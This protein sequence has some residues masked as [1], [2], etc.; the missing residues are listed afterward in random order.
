MNSPQSGGYKTLLSVG[1][2]AKRTGV[3]V[4]ALHFYE[5]KGLIKASRT[6]GNQRQYNR[7]VLRRVSVIKVAQR[8]GISLASIHDAFAA[9]PN[10]RIA[11][12]EDWSKLS[13][14][15]KSDLDD[16]IQRLTRLRDQLNGC[17]GC[18][19][20]SMAACPLRN[21]HDSL[22]AQGAGPRLLMPEI[23]AKKAAPGLVRTRKRQEAS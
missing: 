22:A 23:S 18:G 6:L 17:I 15:W 13:A 9:L 14:R 4:S 8:L 10:N 20:L 12:A 11:S 2:V 16:R 19:C 7:D 3:A 5:S 21:P 1:D